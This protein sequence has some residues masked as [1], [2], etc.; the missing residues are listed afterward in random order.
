[1]FTSIK[2]QFA[3]YKWAIIFSLIGLLGAG[4]AWQ[5]HKAEKLEQENVTIKADLKTVS[6]NFTTFQA[7][8]KKAL[9]DVAALRLE[10]AKISAD[11]TALQNQ[12][13]DLNEISVKPTP[14]GANSKEIEDKANQLSRDVFERIQ[15]SSKGKK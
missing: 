13:D 15:N 4:L 8:T 12:K 14:G 1:M 2:A 7:S 5:Y 11:T 6:T 9:D 3:I 10:F